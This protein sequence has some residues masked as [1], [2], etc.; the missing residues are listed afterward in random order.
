MRNDGR[1]MRFKRL[2]LLLVLAGL[3]MGACEAQ[4]IAP[5]L[6]GPIPPCDDVPHIAAAPALYRPEPIYVANEMPVDEVRAWALRKPGFED[7][8][9]DRD[10][11]GWITLAFSRDAAV[12]QAELAQAFP[13]AGVV[14]VQVDW[15]MADLG[16]LQAKVM[17]KGRPDVVGSGVSATQG[18]VT[19]DLGVLHPDKVARFAA[20]FAGQRVCTEGIDPSD[21][22]VDG[23]QLDRGVGWR[24]LVDADEVGGP[25]LTGIAA[26][27]DGLAALWLRIGLLSDPPAVDFRSEV[28]V[29]FGAVHGSSCP[30]LRFDGVGFDLD[31]SIVYSEIT[32]F[33]TGLCTADAIGHAYVVAI[34]RSMLP[35]GPFTIQLQREEPPGGATEEKTVVDADLSGP[36]ST[37]GANQVHSAPPH[38]EPPRI[39][40]GGRIEPEYPWRYRLDV[41]CGIEWLGEVNDVWWRADLV[42]G[43]GSFVPPQWNALAD[44]DGAVDLEIV[45]TIEPE[46]R[47]DATAGSRTVS[48][49]PSTQAPVPC[50]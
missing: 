41:T 11:H 35:H 46:P 42:A 36:G 22:P 7:I 48:Y 43:A 38:E 28:A 25:Y 12:R 3:A 20:T 29:W 31:R 4:A 13:G 37:F 50:K 18:V 24:L 30:R 2:V 19:V 34:Q 6:A 8:W 27:D 14:A 45:L 16:A 21:V 40:S 32:S 5:G 39:E 26:D 15:T 44:P 17:E 47:I 1:S 9:I 10:H 23:P 33:N 49:R